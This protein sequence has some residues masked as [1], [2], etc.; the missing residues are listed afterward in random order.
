MLFFLN[1]YRLLHVQ[2][3]S[4]G[5]DFKNPHF[6]YPCVRDAEVRIRHLDV[7]LKLILIE[8]RMFRFVR[9]TLKYK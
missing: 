1:L 3:L 8:A 2:V 5:F 9:Q 4:F 6:S 7:L